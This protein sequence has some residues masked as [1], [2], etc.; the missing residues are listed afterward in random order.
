M[1]IKLAA[2]I[3]LS[4]CLAL[5]GLTS[6]AGKGKENG[7]DIFKTE[8]SIK[9]GREI[10][11][12]PLNLQGKNPALVYLG[13][14]IVNAQ[15]GCNDC[16]THPAYAPGGDPYMGEKE[17]VNTEQYLAGGRQFGPF[18][19]SK[20]ITPDANGLPAGLTFEEFADVLRTGVDPDNPG[21][22]LQVMPWPIYGKMTTRDLRA[23]YEYLR[24]I[25]SLPDNPNPGP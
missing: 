10:A 6:A 9:I 22:I 24:A 2:L 19:T 5:P 25:P 20:N 17:M 3:L 23:V 13:S 4:P 15:G 11:P 18:I 1:K 7:K 12:V 8:A 16:H 14:Y 21:E